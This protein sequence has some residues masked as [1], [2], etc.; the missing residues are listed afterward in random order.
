MSEGHARLFAV[1]IPGNGSSSTLGSNAAGRSDEGQAEPSG[2][3]ATVRNSECSDE[4]GDRTNPAPSNEDVD[5][6]QSNPRGTQPPGGNAEDPDVD[7]LD[8]PNSGG[9]PQLEEES[10]KYMDDV[11]NKFRKGEITKL[12]AL[13]NIISILDFDPSRT[14]RAKD[15]AVEFYAK[16]LDEYAALASSAVK[17][18]KHAQVRLQPNGLGSEQHEL[19][20]V[21]RD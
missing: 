16:T 11:V 10:I 21:D 3:N 18:G 5:G 4:R 8:E 2:E 19:R 20:D 7:D 1:P 12:K 6:N 17:R 14:N 13:S 9:R 15:A